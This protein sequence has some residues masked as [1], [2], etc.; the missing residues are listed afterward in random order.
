MPKVKAPLRIIVTLFILVVTSLSGCT[1][2]RAEERHQKS[3]ELRQQEIQ[4][5]QIEL[6]CLKRKQTDP[7]IDCS[8]F[9]DLGGPS[10]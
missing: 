9:H 5:R 7:A 4:R 3:M 6:D 2:H 8:H 1:G 10:K